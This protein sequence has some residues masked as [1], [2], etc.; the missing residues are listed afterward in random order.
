[1]MNLKELLEA[2]KGVDLLKLHAWVT[3]QKPFWG[4]SHQEY[5]GVED[6]KQDSRYVWVT[7]SYR[8]WEPVELK[9]SI[10]EIDQMEPLE[11]AEFDTGFCNGNPL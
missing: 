9:V 3:K 10:W 6:I 7:V 2:S 8:S 11:N 5:L 4:I 1:M